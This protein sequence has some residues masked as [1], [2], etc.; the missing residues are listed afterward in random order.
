MPVPES[1]TPDIT[2]NVLPALVAGSAPTFPVKGKLEEHARFPMLPKIREHAD[3]PAL[4]DKSLRESEANF[5]T[6]AETTPSAMF[7]C[8]GVHLLLRTADRELRRMKS[9]G[10]KTVRTEETDKYASIG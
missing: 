4:R 7:T 5:R 2:S 8:W 9:R 1:D 10:G 3:E 6:L